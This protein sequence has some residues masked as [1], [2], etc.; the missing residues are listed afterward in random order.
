MIGRTGPS[1]VDDTRVI[2][3]YREY[4]SWSRPKLQIVQIDTVLPD[5]PAGAQIQRQLDR[6]DDVVASRMQTPQRLDV[7]RLRS[8]R[9]AGQ[10]PPAGLGG[11]VAE[12]GL[13]DP[14]PPVRGGYDDRPYLPVPTVQDQ[15]DQSDHPVPPMVGDPYPGQVQSGQVVL[16]RDRRIDVAEAGVVV[17]CAV[18]LGQFDP[19]PSS[20]AVVRRAGRGG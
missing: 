16:E 1:P 5:A 10:A 19:E 20:G 6:R 8:D 17:K 9:Q 18:L 7:A 11:D 15:P 13:P 12:Q 3:S 14:P 2:H 4:F